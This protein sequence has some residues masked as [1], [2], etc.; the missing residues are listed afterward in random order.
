MTAYA[1]YEPVDKLKPVADN[2][3][4]VDG[5]EIRMSYPYLPF[6]KV[7]FPTRM[8]VV[9]LSD[10]TLWL[11]SPTPLVDEL[12]SSLEALGRIAFLVAP[13]L[14]HYWWIGDWKARYPQARAYAA[15]GTRERAA[16]RFSGFQA[17]LTDTQPAEWMGEFRQVMVPGDYLTEAV[18]LH[19]ASR[20]LILTDLIQNFEPARFANPLTRWIYCAAGCC[21]PDGKAPVDLRSTFLRYREEVRRAVNLMLEWHP[22]RVILAH[23]RWYAHDAEAELKRAFRWA[24]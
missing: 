22:E 10:G 18:F 13:N 16:K 23:G 8:T 2:I 14:L 12:A 3:W 24:L 20:A 4:V 7:P 11:H 6:I 19:V 15:P 5:P 21:D 1:L 9:R 17:D